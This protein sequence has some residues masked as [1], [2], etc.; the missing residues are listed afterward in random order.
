[1]PGYHWG[2]PS[3]F[4]EI[5]ISA[6]VER[7]PSDGSLYTP[8]PLF[9]SKATLG[10]SFP[11]SKIPSQDISTLELFYYS[12]YS[13]DCQEHKASNDMDFPCDDKGKE[14]K[15][16]PTLQAQQAVLQVGHRAA[17][18]SGWRHMGLSKDEQEGK[19]GRRCTKPKRTFH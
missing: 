6:C 10:L 18:D 13:E 2:I 16:R 4:L 7:A 17:T 15:G 12:S 1:M 8:T 14:K 9:L 3:A 19:S 11:Q 5:T